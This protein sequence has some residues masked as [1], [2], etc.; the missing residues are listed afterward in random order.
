[1]IYQPAEDSFLLQNSLKKFLKNKNKSLK[2]LDMG[3]GSG[4]QAQ[5]CLDLGFKNIIAADI[6]P[7]SIEHLTNQKIN[8]IKTNLYSKISKISKFDL[9]IFNAPYL[10]RDK[11]EPKKSQLATTA[12]K[13][14]YEIILKFLKN[15]KLH[16][17]KEGKILLLFSSLSQPKVIL[18]RAKKLGY[19][20]SLLE[21][22][23]L[24]FEEIYVFKFKL[25]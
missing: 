25:K 5:T 9:I 23:K 11:R 21:S 1:M 4:I 24:F 7:E 12:G 15:S 8:S 10:P 14:G 6:N 22:Q 3:S 13:K 19:N 20:Y 17:K 18:E 2:I 16:L